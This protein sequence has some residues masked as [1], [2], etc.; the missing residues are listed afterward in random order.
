MILV[1]SGLTKARGRVFEHI[2]KTLKN[3]DA[4]QFEHVIT[5]DSPQKQNNGFYFRF[6][7]TGFFLDWPI[8]VRFSNI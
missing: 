7:A 3:L 5:D 8:Q 6:V 2:I 4:A 1:K